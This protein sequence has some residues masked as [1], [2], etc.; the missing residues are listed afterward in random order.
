MYIKKKQ[1]TPFQ[2]WKIKKKLKGFFPSFMGLEFSSFYPLLSFITFRIQT[3]NI[4]NIPLMVI[5]I[6]VLTSHCSPNV[7][8][9]GTFSV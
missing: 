1:K 5:K 4:T 3:Q 9:A 2:T 6:K 7:Q 8:K